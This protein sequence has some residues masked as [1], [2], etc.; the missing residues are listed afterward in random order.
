MKSSAQ[1]TNCLNN[2]EIPVVSIDLDKTFLH[3]NKY[4]SELTEELV[5]IGYYCEAKRIPFYLTTARCK[6]ESTNNIKMAL[7][8]QA[9][10][11]QKSEPSAN[12]SPPLASSIVHLHS[13]TYAVEKINES[14]LKIKYCTTVDASHF[15]TKINPAISDETMSE[16]TKSIILFEKKIEENTAHHTIG[17][18]NIIHISLE[19]KE[20]QLELEAEKT[21]ISRTLSPIKIDHFAFITNQVQTEEKLKESIHTPSHPP[22]LETS[23]K[24]HIF[25]IDDSKRIIDGIKTHKDPLTEFIV[26]PFLLEPGKSFSTTLIDFSSSIGLKEEAEQLLQCPTPTF[27]PDNALLNFSCI[28]Y[29]FTTNRNSNGSFTQ[30]IL[31]IKK[32]AEQFKEKKCPMSLNPGQKINWELLNKQIEEEA[33]KK[34]KINSFL[35]LYDAECY[36]FS[37]GWLNNSKTDRNN[38][39]IEDIILHAMQEPTFT[40][41]KNGNRTAEIL[42]KHFNFDVR[43]PTNNIG[44]NIFQQIWEKYQG[45]EQKA[46]TTFYRLSMNQQIDDASKHLFKKSRSRIQDPMNKLSLVSLIEAARE[47]NWKTR[48]LANIGMP[49][50]YSGNRSYGIFKNEFNFDIRKEKNKMKTSEELAKELLTDALQATCFNK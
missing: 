27:N 23:K 24:V 21:Q 46:V 43:N 32:L 20:I 2:Q 7:A 47:K 28:K 12:H 33:L 16:E 22:V 34:D 6:Q 35:K 30:N 5:A 14:G 18:E 25:H 36:S 9:N 31:Y 40:W 39:T 26:T 3:T 17:N 45:T 37:P 19:S 8:E 42:K 38:L 48:L 13:F 15:F 11:H 44:D 29:L 10:I 4:G 50:F 41:G 1:P 49:G